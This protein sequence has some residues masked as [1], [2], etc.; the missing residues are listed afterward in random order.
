MPLAGLP[1]TQTED[2]IGTM[3]MNASSIAGILGTPTLPGPMAM[4]A[5][6]MI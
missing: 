5:A 1:G 3:P 4:F 6:L 2:R